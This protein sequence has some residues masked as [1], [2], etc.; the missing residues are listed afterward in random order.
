MSSSDR[1]PYETALVLDQ[2]F[3][4]FCQDN[5]DQ[6]LQ[7][8]TEIDSIQEDQERLECTIS[9]PAGPGVISIA[10]HKMVEGD[11]V[12]FESTGLERWQKAQLR[13]LPQRALA[14]LKTEPVKTCS[15]TAQLWKA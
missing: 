10:N 12:I 8:I 1:R 11:P 6:K 4:D 3:L 15:S 2:E 5:L 14:S 9:S 13:E 7:T